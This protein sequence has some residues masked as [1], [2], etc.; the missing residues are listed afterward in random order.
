MYYPNGKVCEQ[1]YWKGNRWV[2]E[3]KFFYDNGKP[4]Y[5]WHYDE[6]GL[7]EGVQ[8]YF[9]R[10]GNLMLV[11][12]WKKGQEQGKMREYYSNGVIKRLTE[13][14]N[15]MID[16]PVVE[17]YPD[18]QIKKKYYYVKGKLDSSRIIY[19]ARVNR[20]NKDTAASEQP[21]YYPV[22]LGTGHFKF[23]DQK[24]RIIAEG[25]YKD[26]ILVTGKKYFYNKNGK[27]RY[28]WIYKSGHVIDVIE[29]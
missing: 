23:Y 3:Y 6:D 24:G 28:I 1:G 4:K 20:N 19:Y 26:G 7:R 5:I 21:S 8:K 12:N 18:G 9:Y 10:N 14:R 15:G 27:L 22:F 29:K 2:G 25:Y 11:G 16:G 13:W 17:F